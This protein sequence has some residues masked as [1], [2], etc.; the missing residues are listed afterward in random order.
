M[1]NRLRDAEGH[2]SYVL[3][4]GK[5]EDK[6]YY[7]VVEGFDRVED[8]A[9]FIRDI[10]QHVQLRILEPVPWILQRPTR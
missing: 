7:V 10:A 9:A 1:R 4:G 5:P 8:A 6:R 2:A 3:Y